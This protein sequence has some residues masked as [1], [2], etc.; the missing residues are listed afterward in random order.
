MEVS[1][2][3]LGE[4]QDFICVVR[5]LLIGRQARRATWAEESA[6]WL[7]KTDKSLYIW[8]D[9][10]VIREYA[11]DGEDIMSTDWEILL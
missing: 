2:Q 1:H 7:D 9:D 4:K 3:L 5:G 10:N 8:G 6:I 11:P